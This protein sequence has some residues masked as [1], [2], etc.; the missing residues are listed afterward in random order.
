MRADAARLAGM[1]ADATGA[2]ATRGVVAKAVGEGRVATTHAHGA[3][4]TDVTTDV[5]TDAMRHGTT[6]SRADRVP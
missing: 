2:S 3:T 1:R 5:T 4:T 6:A